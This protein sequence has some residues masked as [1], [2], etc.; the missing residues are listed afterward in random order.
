VETEVVEV[1]RRTPRSPGVAATQAQRLVVIG[2][3]QI[4]VQIHQVPVFTATTP[5]PVGVDLIHRI[6]V[7]FKLSL[8]GPLVMTGFNMVSDQI[9]SPAH[10]ANS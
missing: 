2:G 7:H 6:G 1:H 3:R 5:T 10:L 8:S 4:E 9:P